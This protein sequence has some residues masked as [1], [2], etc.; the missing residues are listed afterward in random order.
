MNLT[1]KQKVQVH[2]IPLIC[3]LYLLCFLDRANIGNAHFELI[4]D[5]NITEDQFAR[6]AGFFYLGYI[7]AE[8]PSNC[9]LEVF[10]A[11]KWMC[12]IVLTWGL[13]TMCMSLC[14]NTISLYIVRFLIGVAESGF[15]PS[16]VVYL[17]VWFPA[18][19]RAQQIAFFSSAS[20]LAGI[21]GGLIAYLVFSKMGGFLGIAG[22]RWLFIVEGFPTVLMGIVVFFYLPDN[23]SEAKWLTNAEK[24]ELENIMMES[25][26]KY[27]ETTAF[28][29]SPPNTEFEMQDTRFSIPNEPEELEEEVQPPPKKSFREIASTI[30]KK[31]TMIVKETAKEPDIWILSF[32]CFFL[33]LPIIGTTVFLPAIIQSMGLTGIQSN[34]LSSVPYIFSLICLNIVAW[35]S[36]RKDERPLHIALMAG[37]GIFGYIL[38]LLTFGF[39]L[40]LWSQMMALVFTFMTSWSTQTPFYTWISYATKTHKPSTIAMI[41]S[42]GSI[43]GYVGPSIQAACK[44]ATGDFRLG[45]LL[46]S[47]SQIIGIVLILVARSRLEKKQYTLL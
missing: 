47:I 6:A 34:L 9:L 23:P 2:L 17:T 45:M 36:D 32:A 10:G 1:L 38:L 16:I 41:N 5:L 14:T 44:T 12:R 18:N 25:R 7:L 33:L 11:R 3:F 8:V 35:N 13:L 24:A 22:W 21:S 15:F 39:N 26:I 20:S 37:L 27:K 42:I 43:A 46:F 19:A 4:N 31:Y 30:L 29:E 40:P 28:D